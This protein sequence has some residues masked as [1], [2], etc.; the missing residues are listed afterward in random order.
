[1]IACTCACRVIY[2]ALVAFFIPGVCGTEIFGHASHAHSVRR[3]CWSAA[4]CSS[5]GG[6]PL[7]NG[8]HKRHV[9]CSHGHVSEHVVLGG[10]PI[11][12]TGE[13]VSVSSST[14]WT[15]VSKSW[16]RIHQ[17][18]DVGNECSSR[19]PQS[20]HTLPCR[21]TSRAWQQNP[22]AT[23]RQQLAMVLAMTSQLSPVQS[24][25][26]RTSGLR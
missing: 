23:S 21:R 11:A 2:G 4:V 16:G 8:V 7:S 10:L 25:A 12:A 3:W 15:A 9:S 6:L 22:L 14:P 5:A 13:S 17:R 1:M 20:Q 24:G 26:R 18:G 19:W